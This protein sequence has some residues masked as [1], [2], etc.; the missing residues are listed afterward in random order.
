MPL[1]TLRHG[2]RAQAVV[3]E[4]ALGDFAR[5]GRLR[6]RDGL[7]VLAGF[8]PRVVG[9]DAEIDRVV[10]ILTEAHL[11]PPSVSELERSTGRHDLLAMLRLAAARGQVE[12]VERD[13]YYVPAALDQFVEVLSEMGQHGPI[14][15]AAVRDRL[16][17]SRK[18]LIP[19]LEWADGR[20][21]TVREGDGRRLKAKV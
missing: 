19:L 11:S 1:E 13:R 5:A 8:V 12:A 7:V 14:I 16:G 18:Y 3:V 21:I 10:R 9:G 15:P 20:G 2:L 17:I 6:L 4:A